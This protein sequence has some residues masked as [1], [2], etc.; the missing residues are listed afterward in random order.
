MVAT[1]AAVVGTGVPRSARAQDP[2]GFGLQLSRLA[3]RS[4]LRERPSAPSEAILILRRL[5]TLATRYPADDPQLVQALGGV[6]DVA[7][8][9]SSSVADES[10]ITREAIG[11]GPNA[12]AAYAATARSGENTGAALAARILEERTRGRR[13]VVA[14]GAVWHNIREAFL[15]A[16][17]QDK[18]APLSPRFEPLLA[19]VREQGAS[20]DTIMARRLVN[21]R[22]TV[23]SVRLAPA[24]SAEALASITGEIL[25]D[26]RYHLVEFRKRRD[27]G[28]LDWEWTRFSASRIARN[29]DLLIGPRPPTA[30][31]GARR[32]WDYVGALPS[33]IRDDLRERCAGVMADYL[34]LA[35]ATNGEIHG[36]HGG[37]PALRFVAAERF[38]ATPVLVSGIRRFLNSPF[39]G[40]RS[41]AASVLQAIGAP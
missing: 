29:L 18:D 5:Q 24:V 41:L 6:V 28:G 27:A 4:D 14:H 30:P 19:I 37:V 10:A 1:F 20:G 32:A 3:W 2:Y 22:Q 13:D 31:G 11:Y 7:G 21:T 39:L 16:S 9:F 26:L 38:P 17:S 25:D 40:E 35:G 12:L 36:L 23:V 8:A 15:D 34:D 33:E